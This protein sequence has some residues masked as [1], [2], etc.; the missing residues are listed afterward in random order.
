MRW[1]LPLARAL[2][3]L[4]LVVSHTRHHNTHCPGDFRTCTRDMPTFLARRLHRATRVPLRPTPRRDM[5]TLTVVRFPIATLKILLVRRCRPR[6]CTEVMICLPTDN[7]PRGSSTSMATKL[8]HPNC[9]LN[10]IVVDA[11]L[12][13]SLW[14]GFRRGQCRSLIMLIRPCTLARNRIKCGYGRTLLLPSSTLGSVFSAM[15]FAH[16]R[17]TLLS[18]SNG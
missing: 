4:F 18:A 16:R 1:E 9:S 15:R 12:P 6:V 7:T 2:P 10:V 5:G 14:I 17:W 3:K 13:W 11:L 8:P